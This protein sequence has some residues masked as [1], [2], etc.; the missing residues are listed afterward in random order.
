[1]QAER[2][3]NNLSRNSTP[4]DYSDF[5]LSVKD[6]RKRFEQ[7]SSPTTTS[8]NLGHRKSEPVDSASKPRRPPPPKP[9]K[10][11]ATSP[12]ILT[13]SS[14]AAK[15][16]VQSS[17]N[18][19]AIEDVSS[20]KLPQTSVQDA[21]G[22]ASPK[23]KTKSFKPLKKAHSVRPNDLVTT[24]SDTSSDSKK[25]PTTKKLFKR[26]SFEK[27]RMETT[28]SPATNG[29]ANG[30]TNSKNGE[31]GPACASSPTHKKTSPLASMKKRL[32]SSSKSGSSQ[33][34]SPTD[35]PSKKGYHKTF[36]DK[37]LASCDERNVQASLKEEDRGKVVGGS[38]PTSPRVI[39][40]GELKLNLTEGQ[41]G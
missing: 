18:Q 15:P 38:R 1:M 24:N 17:A 23:P 19:S 41:C 3:F 9:L 33:P 20:D 37:V 13:S 34:S 36:S 22:D 32:S 35:H 30:R 5:T 11:M 4:S 16:R 2:D 29:S 28:S 31:T 7:L 21:G 27:A 6:A 12:E 40:D 26:R 8:P 14:S 10:K 25:L 39:E